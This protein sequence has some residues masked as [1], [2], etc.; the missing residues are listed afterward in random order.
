MSEVGLTAGETPEWEALAR[1]AASVRM[2][3]NSD[4]EIFQLLAFELDGA[5]Y[6]VP[7]ERVRQIIRMRPITQVPGFPEDV[8]GVISIRG[9]I[10][11][12]VD[13][14][15]RLGVEPIEPTRGSRIIVAST[16]SGEATGMIVD[17]V[18]EVMRVSAEAIRPA[19]GSESGAIENLCARGDQ[20]VSVIQ[21]DRVLSIDA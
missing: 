2:L 17:S 16:S 15:R 6:A 11:Q 20:F 5:P 10:I 13:L 14:R 19:T 9:E 7:V 3:D 18:R 4:D 8:R 1:N 21:L 12:V